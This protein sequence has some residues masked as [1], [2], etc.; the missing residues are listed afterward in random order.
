MSEHLDTI[1]QAAN[2][3]AALVNKI[4]RYIRQEK[5]ASFVS[6][7][8]KS[9]IE[10][11]ITLT[12]P[13]WYN[14]PRRQ[15]VSIDLRL[16]SSELPAVLGSAAELRDVFVNLILNAVQALPSGGEISIVADSDKDF[17]QIRLTD[18]GTG[19]P[20]EVLSR[21]F[22]PLFTTKGGRGTG[23]G[24]SVAFGVLQEHDGSIEATSEVG[25]GTTFTL[26]LPVSGNSSSSKPDQLIEQLGSPVSVLVVDDENM[27]RTVIERLLTLRGHNV[28]SVSSAREA[29]S[30][31]ETGTFDVVLSDQ[32][33]PE[34]SGRE[35]A[36]KIRSLYPS[37]PVVLLTGDTDLNVDPQDIARVVPKPFQADDLEQAIRSVTQKNAA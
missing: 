26:L 29:L 16:E 25:Q 36:R 20:P 33:M 8:L 17:V 3:G 14:E 32:G 4:Q 22:E 35:L 2:D 10:D 37:L 27:V 24:L 12:K 6:L 15:G 21:I 5:Q 9:L 19:M 13:Y 11:C 23:M 18:T 28:A 34:M 30:A 7:E 1:E 31:L